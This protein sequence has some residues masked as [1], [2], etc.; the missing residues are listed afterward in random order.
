MKYLNKNNGSIFITINMTIAAIIIGI[1]MLLSVSLISFKTSKTFGDGIKAYYIAE[2]GVWDAIKYIKINRGVANNYSI[3]KDNTDN[4]FPE[5]TNN[6]NYTWVIVS[7]TLNQDY[8]IKSIGTYKKGERTLNVSISIN[9]T[10]KVIM[11][12]WLQE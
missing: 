6:Y 10:N 3:S 1:S 8:V 12:D 2:S 9:A 5:Y 4:I 7:N 11:S